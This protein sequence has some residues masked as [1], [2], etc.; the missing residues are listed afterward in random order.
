MARRHPFLQD[1]PVDHVEDGAARP[2]N[3]IEI[4]RVV[5]IGRG[6]QFLDGPIPGAAL[7]A[8]SVIGHAPAGI[9]GQSEDGDRLACEQGLETHG[10]G[11][12]V[13]AVHRLDQADRIDRVA[14]QDGALVVKDVA[15][16]AAL[17]AGTDFRMGFDVDG[18]VGVFSPRC[19]QHRLEGLWSGPAHGDAVV[20]CSLV[21]DE[22]TPDVVLP[23]DFFIEIGRV[24]IL[25]QSVFEDQGPGPFD[26][27]FQTGNQVD[28][29]I[30]ELFQ[31]RRPAAVI[32][33]ALLIPHDGKRW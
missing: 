8:L 9:P 28:L 2:G 12:R 16:I 18:R 21:D 29:G 20:A 11:H 17:P 31:R 22:D 25:A 26:I 6:K 14:Q 27:R 4:G 23:E 15:E 24:I 5:E 7:A 33:D 13:D 10:G 30:Q 3:G 1:E 19:G 32:I